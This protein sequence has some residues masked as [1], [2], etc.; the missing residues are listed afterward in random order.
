MRDHIARAEL[1][2]PASPERVWELL[3]QRGPDPDVMFGAE[4]ISDWTPG[5][6]IR[7]VGEWEGSSFEDRGEILELDPPYRLLV[8]HFSPLSG[9]ADVPENHH[10]LAF[11][12]QRLGPDATHAV[13]EQGGNA[14]ADA[15]AH[16]AANWQAMLDGLARAATR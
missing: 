2:I 14:S 10:H 5:A 9:E 11:L 12:L 15:A 3:T 1:D 16:S 8:T 7:W 4:V 6:S 13:I